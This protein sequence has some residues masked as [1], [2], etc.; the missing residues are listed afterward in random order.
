[1]DKKI[2]KLILTYPIVQGIVSLAFNGEMLNKLFVLYML[3]IL[4][5]YSSIRVK[6]RGYKI[7][8]KNFAVIS[9]V[10]AYIP[11]AFTQEFRDINGMGTNGFIFYLYFYFYIFVAL[12][13]ISDAEFLK[14][15]H[16][17]CCDKDFVLKISTI[18]AALLLVTLAFKIGVDSDKW[19]TTTFRAWFGLPHGLSY[20]LMVFLLLNILIWIKYKKLYTWIFIALFLALIFFTGVRTSFVAVL[21]IGFCYFLNMNVRSKIIAIVLALVGISTAW[22]MGLFNAL[23]EKTL[24]SAAIGAVGGSRFRIWQSS[25]SSFH[26]KSFFQKIFGFGYGNLLAYNKNNGIERVHAHNDFIITVVCY[27]M[28][29]FFIYLYGLLRYIKSQFGTISAV[30]LIAFVAFANGYFIYTHVLGLHC[31]SVLVTFYEIDKKNRKMRAI[32]R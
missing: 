17:V 18:Y 3:L 12:F 2:V 31:I 24:Q 15:Y 14:T 20:E 21:L 32:Y 5:M 8:V 1:M 27:G 16:A 23:I 26:S 22:K 10:T 30:V 19:G 7:K 11:I 13:L 9:F 4:S 29:G 28:T 25:I 6:K